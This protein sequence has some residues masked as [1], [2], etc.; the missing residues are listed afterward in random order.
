MYDPFLP[1]EAPEALFELEYK[2]LF[3]SQLYNDIFIIYPL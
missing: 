1:Q 3:I 2:S